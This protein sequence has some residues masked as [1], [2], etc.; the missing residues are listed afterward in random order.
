MFMLV[1]LA[2]AAMLEIVGIAAIRQGLLRAAWPWLLVGCA[3][4]VG[5]GFVVNTSRSVEFNRLMGV[6]ITVFFVVSQVVAGAFFGERPSAGLVVGGALI[7]A[8]GLVI[9]SSSP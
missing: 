6:Y 4:V 5:Y 7:V 3:L 1:P 2:A 8:G 9:Q